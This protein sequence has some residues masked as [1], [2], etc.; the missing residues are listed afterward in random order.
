MAAQ[1]K[2]ELVVES[3]SSSAPE[4]GRWLWTLEDTRRRTLQ[5]IDGIGQPML[6]ELPAGHD[7]TIGTILYHI[8]LIEAS[9]LYDDVL[10][11]AAPAEIEALFPHDHRD[12]DGRL[13]QV[14]GMSLA[15][16]LERMERVRNM[17]LQAYRQMTLE[18]FRRSRSL[19]DY[20]VTPEWVLHHLMQHEAEH[21]G[22]IGA[23]RVAIDRHAGVA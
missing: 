21:R 9:W 11:T 2:Q 20:N 19:P 1:T 22:Q 13:T 17:L 8:A 6:D 12:A 23:I 18:D 7:S 16:H 15:E 3:R 5:T 14:Y 4:I 10:V